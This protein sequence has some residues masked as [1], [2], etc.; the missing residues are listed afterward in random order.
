MRRPFVVLGLLGVLIGAGCSS[1]SGSS[2]SSSTTTTTAPATTDLASLLPAS[3]PSG[4]PRQPDVAG[5]GGPS[6]LQQA[7]TFDGSPGA[8][9]ALTSAG[10]VRGHE[11]FW[12]GNSVDEDVVVLF[13][14][15][16]PAGAQSYLKYSHTSL[17]SPEANSSPTPFA[18]SVIPGAFGVQVPTDRS[19]V[20][21]VVFAKGVYVAQAD[22]T[23]PPHADRAAEATT[24]AQFLYGRLP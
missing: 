9:Q 4:Y 23:G 18:V 1:S 19:W 12:I 2:S 14:F 6:D 16:T 10:F 8:R 24:L 22:A 11:R 5:G 21:T 17:S 3:V 13:Q 15:A 20:T 7:V